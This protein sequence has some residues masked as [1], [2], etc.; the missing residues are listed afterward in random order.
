MF[1]AKAEAYTKNLRQ[2]AADDHGQEQHRKPQIGLDWTWSMPSA[3]QVESY[4]RFPNE[5][6]PE[7]ILEILWY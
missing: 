4:C 1:R 7:T 5:R 6:E 2:E 3:T